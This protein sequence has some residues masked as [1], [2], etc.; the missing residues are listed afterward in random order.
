MKTLTPPAPKTGPEIFQNVG[1]E[2]SPIY[3]GRGVLSLLPGILQDLDFDTLYAVADDGV[4][5]IHG[6]AL[7]RTLHGVRHQVLVFPAGE[8]SKSLQTFEALV[9]RLLELGVTRRS[10]ILGFGGGVSGNLAGF[11]AGTLFR[12]IR[13]AHVPTTFQAQ[14][15]STLS[16]KQALNCHGKN[17]IGCFHTPCFTLSDTDWMAT[18]PRRSLLGGMSESIKNAL[19]RGGDFHDYLV[20]HLDAAVAEDAEQLHDLAHQSILSKLAI[21]REDPTE[22]GEAV[23]LEY[24][25]TLAHALEMITSGRFTH[26]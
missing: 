9:G 13:L 6:E 2:K 21:L 1:K 15:D 17:L 3:F 20:E 11:L 8:R 7:R 26:G 18:E 4:E 5:R 12:G 25:H 14:T 16:R 10:L 23:I 19:I 24:G 22:K